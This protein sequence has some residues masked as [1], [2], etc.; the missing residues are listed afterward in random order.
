MTAALDQ[1]VARECHRCKH[2]RCTRKRV[3]SADDPRVAAAFADAVA[4]FPTNDIKYH[5]NK[6]R[7]V[8]WAGAR[9]RHLYMAVARDRASSAVLNEKPHLEAEKLQ[10]LQ[11]HD[12]ECG[13][14]YGLLPLCV[15]MPVRAAD[16]LDRARGI[17]RGCKGTVLGWSACDGDVLHGVTLWNKLPTVILRKI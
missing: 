14:L 5:V 2:E 17:L 1:I 7:A 11:R 12:K 3:A 13:G 4:I 8:Q 6:L 16:H 9:L 10:W 15:G